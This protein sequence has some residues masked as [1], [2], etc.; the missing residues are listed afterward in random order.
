MVINF[1]MLLAFGNHVLFTYNKMCFVSITE[2]VL[3]IFKQNLNRELRISRNNSACKGGNYSNLICTP[4]NDVFPL[5]S[6]LF[7]NG[8]N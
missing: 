7:S 3:K 8:S 1:Y 4:A 6:R 5:T 2:L